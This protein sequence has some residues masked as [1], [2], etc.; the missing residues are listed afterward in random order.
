MH[1]SRM[2][3]ALSLPYRGICVQGGSLS[4]GSL[5]KG[6]FC[7]GGLCPGGLCP[8][9]SVWGV[10]VWGV[11]GLLYIVI[12]CND[13]QILSFSIFLQS[14]QMACKGGIY[15]TNLC[16]YGGGS[17]SRGFSLSGGG[18]LCPGGISVRETPSPCGQTN[19]CEIITLPQTSFAGGNNV[20]YGIWIF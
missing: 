20:T 2:R 13:C 7:S 11:W 9:V 10:S 12:K 16:N 3:T 6:G 17:L 14:D 5:S 19:T 18:G 4:R 8:G 15:V 1:S